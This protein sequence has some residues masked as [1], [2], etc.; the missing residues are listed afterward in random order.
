MSCCINLGAG[1][2]AEA[3]VHSA[4][5][6]TIDSIWA[7]DKKQ[8]TVELLQEHYTAATEAAS[9]KDEHGAGCNALT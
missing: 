7:S 3:L 4:Q 8:P 6:N 9:K 2:N 5:R 1:R